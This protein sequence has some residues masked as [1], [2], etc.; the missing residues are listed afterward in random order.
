[1]KPS[2]YQLQGVRYWTYGDG[3]KPT[4]LL[5]HG[6]RGTHHGLEKIVEN[7]SD[8][9][10]IIPDLP[11]FG[12]SRPFTRG[13]HTLDQYV[14]FVHEFQ[15]TAEAA[16]VLGHSFGSIVASH[17][18]ARYPSEVQHLILINPISAPALKGPKAAMTKAAMFYYWL[19]KKSPRKVS[20]SILS[21]QKIVDIMSHQ[22][23]VSRD[24]EL[25][26]FVRQQH[27]EHFST[28]ASPE[29]VSQAFR[30]SVSHTVAD[31]VRHLTMPTLVIGAE[32]DQVSPAHTQRDF[33]R[34]L[35]DGT[36][37]QLADVGHLTHYEQ[38]R[39]VAAAIR[40]FLSE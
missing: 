4:I 30:A 38:P 18:A 12:A 29:I 15:K 13:E 33:A 19:A 25:R 24:P 20:R 39:E 7:L 8:F 9:H 6:F 23:T 28:F 35:P 1:M 21:H 27:R 11:G 32:K 16:I 3:A 37:V 31:V 2:S 40:T 36:Y 22:M 34:A 26:E 5:I 14:E 17:Y 10:C